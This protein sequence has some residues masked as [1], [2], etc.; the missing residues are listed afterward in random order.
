MTDM[1]KLLGGFMGLAPSGSA[2]AA[3]PPALSATLL[4]V[5]MARLIPAPRADTLYPHYDLRTDPQ[6][7]TLLRVVNDLAEEGVLEPLLVLPDGDGYVVYHDPVVFQAVVAL[8]HATAL[9]RV[10]AATPE[11][12][13]LAALSR[14]QHMRRPSLLDLADVARRLVEDF[15]YPREVV[16]RHLAQN[17]ETQK[18]PDESYVSQL[19]AIAKL[20]EAAREAVHA[21]TLP[22]SHARVIGQRCGQDVTLA[23]RA[24][25]WC[26]EQHA[27][28]RGL[29]QMLNAVTP[30]PGVADAAW[31][32]DDEQGVRLLPNGP[33]IA[34]APP[35]PPAEL[36]YWQQPLI[37]AKPLQVTEAARKHI[38]TIHADDPAHPLV[39]SDSLAGLRHWLGTIRGTMFPLADLEAQLLG[40]MEA[41]RTALDA[42][43]HSSAEHA[44][45]RG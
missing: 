40:V 37:A 26:V 45:D 8:R 3:A 32:L 41:A 31:L 42:A 11:M 24:A 10:M 6:A 19:V 21:G 13:L 1:D 34:L 25:R 30:A 43:Q 5:P 4:T 33:T 28:V 39:T 14:Q 35:R 38:V 12:L 17:Q 18:A 20:P 15:R 16:A 27:T 44:A 23:L 9:V 36:H 2:A 7:A 22:F 29:E